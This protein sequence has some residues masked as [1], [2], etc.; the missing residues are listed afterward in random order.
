MLLGYMINWKFGAESNV[1]PPDTRVTVYVG[2]KGETYKGVEVPF[3]QIMTYGRVHSNSV[4]DCA[5]RK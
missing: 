5:L 4:H 2:P 1:R 3:R